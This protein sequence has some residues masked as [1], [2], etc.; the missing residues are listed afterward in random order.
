MA[1]QMEEHWRGEGQRVNTIEHATVAFDQVTPVL[2]AAVALDR[3]EHEA[4]E[5][6]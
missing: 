4:A 2:D 6:A 1:Q 3:R 5:E